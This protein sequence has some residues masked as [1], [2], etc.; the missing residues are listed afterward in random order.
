M[1]APLWGFWPPDGA[2]RQPVRRSRCESRDGAGIRGNRPSEPTFSQP[3]NAP[4]LGPTNPAPGAKEDR[5]TASAESL[6]SLVKK[7]SNRPL[8]PNQLKN[9]KETDKGSWRQRTAQP[10]HRQQQRCC[11]RKRGH[12][13]AYGQFILMYGKSHYNI[14]I[15]LQLK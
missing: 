12:V 5:Q 10:E 7:F 3:L 4:Y 11:L 15:M 1:E 14:V 6:N 2:T 13:Y 9:K 8:P